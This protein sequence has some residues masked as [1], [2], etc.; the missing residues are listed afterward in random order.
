MELA[1]LVKWPQA[2]PTCPW[3]RFA[4]EVEVPSS[5]YRVTLVR[6]FLSASFPPVSVTVSASSMVQA[7]LQHNM[8]RYNHRD[9]CPTYSVQ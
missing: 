6:I 4:R 3:L 1:E 7:P 8:L 2:C 5:S 9:I